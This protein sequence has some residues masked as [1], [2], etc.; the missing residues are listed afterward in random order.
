MT[1]FSA[2]VFYLHDHHVHLPRRCWH[3]RR[4]S[5][6][7]SLGNHRQVDRGT[8]ML[9]PRWWSSW[10]WWWSWR[11]LSWWPWTP[12]GHVVVIIMIMMVIMTKMI[13]LI[14]MLTGGQPCC[15][16]CVKNVMLTTWCWHLVV[17]IT[18]V[19]MVFYGNVFVIIIWHNDDYP[20][21]SLSGHNYD[22]WDTYHLI[23]G[24]QRW[25]SGRN[26]NYRDAMIIIEAQW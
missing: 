8:S 20:D 2:G 1:T 21:T 11:W 18:K 16:H 5:R 25:L 6:G 7:Q 26:D 9:T 13:I 12:S 17:M 22:Y 3:N 4:S 23:I 19:L 24:T 10:S 14:A 15:Q